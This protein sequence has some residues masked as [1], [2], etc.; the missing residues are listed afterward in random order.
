MLL[1]TLL[2]RQTDSRGDLFRLK[3]CRLP[4]KTARNRRSVRLPTG[5]IFWITVLISDEI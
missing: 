4:F 3:S 1:R 2:L 5:H